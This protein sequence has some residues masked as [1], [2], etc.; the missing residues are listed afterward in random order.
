VTAATDRPRSAVRVLGELFRTE[1]RPDPHPLYQ[2]L[3][4]RGSSFRSPLG[5]V[6]VSGYAACRD[7]L[8]QPGLHVEDRPLRRRARSVGDGEL[9]PFYDSILFLNGDAH[10]RVRS[11]VQS[12]FTPRALARLEDRLRSFARDLLRELAA[13]PSGAF[14]AYEDFAWP[15]QLNSLAALLGVPRPAVAHVRGLMPDLVVLGTPRMWSDDAWRRRAAAASDRLVAFLESLARE[16]DRCAPDGLVRVLVGE[17]RAGRLARHDLVATLSAVVVAGVETTVGLL[18]NATAAILRQPAV[19][20]AVAAGPLDDR[21]VDELVR[22]GTPIHLVD[23]WVRG[24]AE[25]AGAALPDGAHVV[26]LL[27]AANR[28]PAVFPEPDAIDL[29]RTGPALGFGGGV[30]Y[31]LGAPLARLHV[32]IAVPELFAAFPGLRADGPPV[33]GPHLN[34]HGYWSVPVRFRP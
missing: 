13:R 7:A 21:A 9:S 12:L 27:G 15:V 30:H 3:H 16:A 19:A 11:V 24:G 33:L 31:C 8:R 4:A 34:P 28:D 5:T 17:Q 18:A 1:P 2:E 23:R 20:A 29:G 14:D 25:V 26:L 6:Y 22:I 32:R 10:R